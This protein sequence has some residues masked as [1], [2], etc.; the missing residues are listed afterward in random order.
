MTESINTLVIGA[1]VVGLA[2]ARALAQSGREVVLIERNNGVGEETSSRNSEVIHAGI[3]YPTGSLKARLCVAGKH[4]LYEYCAARHIPHRRLGKLIVAI[5]PE[6][7]SRLESLH[8]QAIANGVA[9]LEPMTAASLHDAEPAVHAVA[10]LRSPSTGIVDN[11]ALMNALRADAED[12]GCHVALRSAFVATLGER[13]EGIR[14]RLTSDGIATD[15]V[16]REIVNAAGLEAVTVARN[17]EC[18]LALP[19]AAYAKG[20]YFH[21]RGAH[22]FRH[23]V[24]PL[25]VAGGLGIHVTL[26]LGGRLRFGPDV[27][28]VDA[29]DYEV[30]TARRDAFVAAIRTYWPSVEPERLAPSYAGIRPKLL[31]DGTARTDF[32]ILTDERPHS[33]LVH[34]LGIESPGLTACLA[35]GDHVRR[36]LD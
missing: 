10:A 2:V 16:A 1:G 15:I 18:S 24:Y 8:A 34:L 7:R 17:L 19:V 30:S 3:Y 32:E 33:R 5:D 13:A 23:L 6:Q 4:A 28:W 29:I 26:D 9:D 11:H 20:N 35:L 12:A 25:P 27:E 36:L 21:Y 22:P 31:R 14:L